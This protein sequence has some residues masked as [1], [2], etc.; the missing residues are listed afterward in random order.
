[1]ACVILLSVS[2]S[3]YFFL[4]DDLIIWVCFSGDRLLR[5]LLSVGD[6]PVDTSL[7]FVRPELALL[8]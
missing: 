1:M 5:L 3:R 4:E 8:G 6:T 7:D 2:P